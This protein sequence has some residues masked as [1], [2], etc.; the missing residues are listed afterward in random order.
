[1]ESKKTRLCK[2]CGETKAFER[3]TWFWSQRNGATGHYCKACHIKKSAAYSKKLRDAEKAARPEKALETHRTCTICNETKPF[4]RGT[5]VWNQQNGAVG[6]VC[7]ACS[8]QKCSDSE[9]ARRAVDP[10]FK[11]ARNEAMR[12]RQRQQYA[13]DEAWR[14]KVRE[15]TRIAGKVWKLANRGKVNANYKRRY[16]AKK[17]RTPAWLTEDDFWL[18]EEAYNLAQLRN[19]VTGLEWHV[20]HIIPLQGAN[21]SGLHVPTN[22]QV[23]LAA[24]N[25]SKGAKWVPL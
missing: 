14:T 10:E 15:R 4:A 21:V 1:M 2:G 18:M 23:I 5:W 9:L 6:S 24:D 20:D 12:V 8:T 11:A 25:L 17:N 7:R 16:T 22:L 3:G 13:E 19:K